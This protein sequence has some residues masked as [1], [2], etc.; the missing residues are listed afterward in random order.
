MKVVAFSM[1]MLASLGVAQTPDVS[2]AG[3]WSVHS[4]IAGNESD[5]ACTFAQDGKALTGSCIN[6]DENK[7]VVKITGSV[8][9][10]KVTWTY[11]SDYNGT[12]L[13]VKY[14]GTLAAGKITGDANVDPFGVSGD[15]TA[16]MAK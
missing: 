2:V 13:V 14:T 7:T 3:K 12:A 1:L 11:N 8:D 6:A 15:F 9:G 4:S 5:Q 16:V 10:T